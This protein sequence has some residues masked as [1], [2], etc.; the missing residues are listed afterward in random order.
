MSHYRAVLFDWVGTLVHY[1]PGR[2]RLRRAHESLGRPIDEGAFEELALSLGS[3]YSLPDVKEAMAT[4][5]CSPELHRLA[6]MLWFERAGVDADLAEAIYAMEFEPATH[7]I[8]PD[9]HDV[10]AEISSLGVSVAVVTNFHR[11][12]RPAITNY[13][14]AEFVDAVVI[15]AENGF[16]KPDERMFTTA[17]DLLAVDASDS[18]MVGDSMPSDGAAASLGIDTLVLPMPGEVSP[19]GLDAVVRLVR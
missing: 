11:D 10:L 3:A 19:R 14:L 2:W 4:E 9:T 5:D 13:G 15:S 7:P 18:L 12:I 1:Q 8:Y 16:Q 6:N 17:L